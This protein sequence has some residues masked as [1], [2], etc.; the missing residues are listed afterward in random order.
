MA[1]PFPDVSVFKGKVMNNNEK[2]NI[3]KCQGGRDEPT[4]NKMKE[5]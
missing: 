2:F 5:G 4:Y 1:S 3:T